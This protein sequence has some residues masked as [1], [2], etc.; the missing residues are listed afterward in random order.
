MVEEGSAD[1][2]R[3]VGADVA[4]ERQHR[5]NARM[6]AQHV[7]GEVG[8]QIELARGQIALRQR[9]TR[10]SRCAPQGQGAVPAVV[11]MQFGRPLASFYGPALGWSALALGAEQAG[12]V[13]AA[14][15]PGVACKGVYEKSVGR[16]RAEFD[17]QAAVARAVARTGAKNFATGDL[18]AQSAGGSAKI[19]RARHRSALLPNVWFREAGDCPEA[20]PSSALPWPKEPRRPR[21]SSLNATR[22]RLQASKARNRT[23]Q[24]QQSDRRRR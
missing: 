13:V 8:V 6:P 4:E 22:H 14:V 20:S 12:H 15:L 19:R 2:A 7:A 10:I 16:R 23:R 18:A 9:A 5:A 3:F 1:G 24:K 11:T 21:S 17:A